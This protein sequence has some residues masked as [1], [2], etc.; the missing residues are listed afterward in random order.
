[1]TPFALA[2]GG[3]VWIDR[4]FV[5]ESAGLAYA[6]DRMLPKGNLTLNGVVVA[7]ESTDV[8]TPAPDPAHRIDW[9]RNIPRLSSELGAAPGPI[10]PVYIDLPAGPKGSL[11]QG[12]ETSVDFPNSHL[13]YAMTWFGFALTTMIMLAEWIRRQQG[14][15]KPSPIVERRDAG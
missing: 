13:G 1:M 15:S 6:D 14:G 8:F 9:V 4:G 10:A 3:T 2:G 5:P 11:P 7:S 12:G